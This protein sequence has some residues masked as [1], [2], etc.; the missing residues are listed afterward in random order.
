M[1]LEEA[2]KIVNPGDPYLKNMVKALEIHPWLNSDED[3][4]RLKAAKLVLKNKK[5]IV[6]HGAKGGYKVK[7]V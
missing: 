5:R 7:E 6:Y 3:T 2:I 4:L 1:T